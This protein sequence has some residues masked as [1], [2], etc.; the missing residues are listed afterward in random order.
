MPAPVGPPATPVA[1]MD[2]ARSHFGAAVHGGKLYVFGGGGDGFSSLNSVEC[3]DPAAD[4]WESRAPMSLRRSGIACVT[5]GDR[6]YVCGGGFKR[7]DGT[8]DFKSIV[9]AYLPEEDRWEKAPF[10]IMR[11][12]APAAVALNG[13]AYLFGGHHPAAAGGPLTDPAF[14]FCERLDPGASRWQECDPLPTPRFSLAA[15]VMPDGIWALGGGAFQGETFRNLDV[16]EVYDP[17]TQLWAESKVRLPWPAAGLHAAVHDGTLYVAGGNDGERISGR[18]ARWTGTGW[19]RLRDLPEGRVMGT[20]A[21]VDGALLLAGGRERD[22]Q[23]VTA[24]V[25]RLR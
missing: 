8:F 12:D 23:T 16:I 24:T 1:P 22:G 7:P 18:V 21:S 3:Y 14:D 25:F 9:E 13:T 5:I 15:A 20:M 19:E 2:E 10:L 17:Y 4:R 6:I 11:H